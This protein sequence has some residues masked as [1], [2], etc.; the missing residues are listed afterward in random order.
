L[1]DARPAERLA[2]STVRL[3]VPATGRPPQRTCSLYR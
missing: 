2:G 3:P 1:P